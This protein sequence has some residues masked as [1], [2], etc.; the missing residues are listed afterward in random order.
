MAKLE[1]MSDYSDLPLFKSPGA[2]SEPD[3]TKDALKDT[4]K[5]PATTSAPA[6]ETSAPKKPGSKPKLTLRETPEERAKTAV[7]KATVAEADLLPAPPKHWT[8]SELTAQ[9][10]GVVEPAFTQIWVQGEISNYRPAA[11]GHVYFSLKDNGA[12]ISAAVFGWGAQRKKTP[13]FDLK[14]GMQVLCRGKISVYPARGTYQ[15]I[16]DQVEPMGAGALQFAFEQLKAKLAAE[17]LFDQKRKR[18]LPAFPHRIAVVTSPSGA[19][20]RDMLT[21]MARRAP[22]VHVMIVPAV[23]QGDTA[24]AQIIKGLE[25]ANQHDLGD[26]V[27]LAR[28]GGSIEDLWCFNDENLARAIAKS[29]LPVISAV[30]HE[31]DFTI[32]DFVADLR[33]PTPSAAAEIVTGHWVDTSRRLGEAKDRLFAFI[34][35]DLGHRKNLL[36]HLMARVVNPKDRLREQAQRCDDL[37]LRL[38]RAVN[39]RVERRRSALD[40]IMGKLDALSPL[41]VLDRGYSILK[42]PEGHVIKSVKQVNPGQKLQVTFNDGTTDVQAI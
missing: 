20:I 16:V 33:A 11:S 7:A 42:T 17:G 26:I 22:N 5:G 40:Q 1:K 13:G 35:R 8:V 30:G 9:I 27:V 6:G 25:L 18:P 10:R 41:K 23:V 24:A 29:R 39:Q 21:I 31:I 19:A 4:S 15:I 14:D 37:A 32:S 3:S 2:T 36:S 28:G 34:A 38:E 12:S